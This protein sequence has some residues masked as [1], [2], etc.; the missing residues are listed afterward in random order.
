[1]P[2]P[3]PA[4]LAAL[5]AAALLLPA[6]GCYRYDARANNLTGHEVRV[7]IHKGTRQR[8]V[9][10]ALVG[11]GGSVGWTGSFNGPV[12]MR[13]ESEGEVFDIGLPRRAH[14]VVDVA[15]TGDGPSVTKTVG[16]EAWTIQPG[17]PEGC[18]GDCCTEPKAGGAPAAAPA[19]AAEPVEH[20]EGE[21]ID[22]VEPGE[23]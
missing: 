16:E 7:S 22:L 4:L 17:C 11:S 15:S 8:E 10:T 12:I 20:D 1:M 21:M 19:E 5:A 3:Q 9:S 2:R 14:T 23:G 6:S 18:E 13:V